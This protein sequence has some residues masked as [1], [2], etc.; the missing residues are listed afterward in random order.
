MSESTRV[1]HTRP[2]PPRLDPSRA[3][4]WAFITLALLIV[5][6][7]LIAPLVTVFASAFAEGAAAFGKAL[8][9]PE[10]RSSIRLTLLI[11]GIVVPIHMV[12]GVATAWAITRFDFRGKSFLIALIDLPFTV[13]PVVAGLMLVLLFG[14]R[15]LFG[16]WLEATDVRIVYAVPGL[17]LATAF[18]TFP[19]VARSLIPLMSAQG[20]D[21]EEAAATLGARGWD[22]FFRVTLPNIKFGLLYGAVL[23]TARAL[24]EFGAV[25]VVSGHIRGKTV[26]L[27][28]HVEIL[29]S[30]Y[31]QVAAFSAATVLTLV[32][33]VTLVG[34]VAL[35]RRVGRARE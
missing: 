23:C 16:P 26:T 10:T 35:Q 32:A 4:Q 5:A 19:F 29:Y 1:A 22:I 18:V 7:V 8:R 14:A 31:Q 20:R 28:L 15:G 12:V 21:E 27:P 6:F 3:V 33:L 34:K 11:V 2:N 17:V 13:S 25:S 24:G 9:T 30:D